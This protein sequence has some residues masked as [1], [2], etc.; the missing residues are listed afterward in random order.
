MLEHILGYAYF[1]PVL[2]VLC[3]YPWVIQVAAAAADDSGGTP[4]T[5]IFRDG[6]S[7]YDI[8]GVSKRSDQQEIKR[9]F[10]KLAIRLHPDKLG[11]FES[12]EAEGK[13]NDIFVKVCVNAVCMI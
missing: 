2:L 13:A 5:P 6:A 11:P 4:R 7:F 9:V 12:V 3:W 10:R 1:L 8:L